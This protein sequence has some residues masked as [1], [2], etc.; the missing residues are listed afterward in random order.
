MTKRIGKKVTAQVKLQVP[1]RSTT[2]VPAATRSISAGASSLNSGRLE[3]NAWVWS[4]GS[5]R[6]A[7]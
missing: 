2:A 3:R 4:F 6:S 1:A 5:S 7:A